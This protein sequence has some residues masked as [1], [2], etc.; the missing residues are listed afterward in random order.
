MNYRVGGNCG[1]Q[2]AE[3]WKPLPETQVNT[4]R[5][6]PKAAVLLKPRNS[7]RW[8]TY[9]PLHGNANISLNPR[10]LHLYVARLPHLCSDE[11]GIRT[12]VPPL[13]RAPAWPSPGDIPGHTW[14]QTSVWAIL[15]ILCCSWWKGH[16]AEAA[17][18]QMA[19]VT[20]L[21]KL[22]SAP[23]DR[24]RGPKREDRFP[25]S[26]PTSGPPTP[27]FQRGTFSRAEAKPRR[28]LVCVAGLSQLPR[29]MP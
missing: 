2:S 21:S 28:R 29:S 3:A 13:Q 27:S 22:H 23:K 14:K 1:L 15:R 4:F 16:A 25:G 24:G 8:R 12:P 6:S 10:N 9:L 20:R 18:E 26:L 19:S 17:S 11:A 5:S 7:G